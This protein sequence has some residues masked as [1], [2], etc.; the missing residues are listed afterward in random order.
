MLSPELYALMRE[1]WLVRSTHNDEGVPVGERW[2]FR[3]RGDNTHLTARAGTRSS[4]TTPAATGT[5]RKPPF[6]KPLVLSHKC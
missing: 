2:L 5:A 3:G 6:L 1:W 4:L